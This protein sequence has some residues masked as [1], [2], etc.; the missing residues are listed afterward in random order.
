MDLK[1][2]KGA[3]LNEDCI[4]EI[5]GWQDDEVFYD[6]ICELQDDMTI[7]Y[8]ENPNRIGSV[9]NDFN[10][11]LIIEIKRGIK[12]FRDAKAEFDDKNNNL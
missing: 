2:I 5:K 12:A 11:S 6:N 10:I 9:V 7:E 3:I 1:N 4:R 8:I